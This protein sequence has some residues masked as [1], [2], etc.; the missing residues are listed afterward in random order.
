MKFI[1]VSSTTGQGMDQWYEW[2]NNQVE[3]RKATRAFS[4]SLTV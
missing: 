3:K 2:L 4:S 1:E